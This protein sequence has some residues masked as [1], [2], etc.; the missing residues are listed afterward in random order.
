MNAKSSES[1]FASGASG[2]EVRTLIK[3][4]AI[5]HWSLST[6]DVK[7]AFLNAPAAQDRGVVIVQP[8]RI[9]QEAGVLQD[10]KE[11]W[12]VKKALYGL[13]TSPR[14]WCDHRDGKIKNFQWLR[15]GR[16][17]RVQATPQTDIWLVQEQ[18]EQNVWMTKGALATYVDD[19]LMVGETEII[20]G[21]IDQVKMHWKIGEPE[22]VMEGREPVRLLGMEI[23]KR[24]TSYVVHQQAYITNLLKE[25]DEKDRCA[26]S[27]VRT[28]E[29]EEQPT[30]DQVLQAQKETG[31]L[32]WVAG[33]TR[34][35]LSLGV[36]V[37]SQWASKRPLQVINIGKQLRAH[38]RETIDEVMAMT[39]DGGEVEEKTIGDEK[40]T[41]QA[42]DVYT[43]ASYGSSELKSISGVVVFV[44]GTPV[45]WQTT[46]QPFI[47]LS[48]A[49]AELMALLEGLVAGRST[50]ALVEAMT[51]EKARVALHSDS[52]AAIAIATGTTS[53]WRT[54]HLRIR[55]AGLT[56]AIKEKEITLDHVSGK[57]LVADGFTKQLVGPALGRFKRALALRG[58]EKEE[59]A[60]K[61]IDITKKVD[62]GFTRGI[63]LLVAAASLL[64][65]VEAA[66][67][68][69][70][71]STSEWWIIVLITAAIAVLVDIAFRV[72]TSGIQR[73]FRPK[74]EIKVKLLSP[75]ARLPTRG[76][77]QAAGLDLYSNIETL[78]P[79][80]ESVLIKTGLAIELP[81]GTYGR[82]APRSS[83]AIRGIETGAGVVDRDFRGEV[84]VLL[85]NWSDDDLRVY[86]GDRVAQLVVERILEVGVNHVEDLSETQRGNRGFGYSAHEEA[87]PW[88]EH[89]DPLYQRQ[90][91]G[92]SHPVDRISM[93]TMRVRSSPETAPMAS[94]GQTS[95][96][97]REGPRPDRP[98]PAGHLEGTDPG[99]CH[100][101]VQIGEV[102][103]EVPAAVGQEGHEDLRVHDPGLRHRG[104][105]DAGA[106][107][108][109]R[110]ELGMTMSAWDRYMIRRGPR[111]DYGGTWV[112]LDSDGVHFIARDPGDGRG[113]NPRAE[114]AAPGSREQ[115]QDGDG[116]EQPEEHRR[117]G[118]P[119]VEPLRLV[120]TVEPGIVL[121]KWCHEEEMAD[122]LRT[123]GFQR[124]LI[125]EA[126]RRVLSVPPRRTSAK[127]SW[128]YLID[129][130]GEKKVGIR[131]HYQDR[132]KLYDFEGNTLLE[133]T[134]GRWRMTVAWHATSRR[135]TILVDER[136]G[137]R[138]CLL[139]LWW[140]YTVF[141]TA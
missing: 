25:Y 97:D 54:G 114:S 69:K 83:L 10:S 115:P 49:E 7:T 123:P 85:R 110:A 121:G 126:V 103:S 104:A 59:I 138:G 36:G 20:Q 21:F 117:P 60:V 140:G 26:L 35:D 68:E 29:E 130:E 132:K 50:A 137:K 64:G 99:L 141:K 129:F 58:G 106:E 88:A 102:R 62:P 57:V 112:M 79:P 87:Y 105:Y 41:I 43:D 89:D 61:K 33:R 34:P 51:G 81:A 65:R 111:R 66:E 1:T 31:E 47:T 73:W 4:A 46:R 40:N 70:A 27:R 98:E 125:N 22:W 113:R 12:L 17:V 100:R 23:E 139:D 76:S 108:R 6:L 119:R 84:K 86:K 11:L 91:L 9:F 120:T 52:T 19:V 45:G 56:E 74:E 37:M 82:I 72:G 136:N 77:D 94:A 122:Y 107:E 24:G 80:G 135:K 71:E 15:G 131:V 42:V 134:W 48:T 96:V 133:E 95:A 44:G 67:V 128:D 78:V 5:N 63:G 109:R 39:A 16:P 30:A 55:A 124:G 8:P 14:D 32:L 28:P 92:T 93:R 116:G 90:E 75:E 38:L 3:M 127:D 53:S 13:V 18:D 101:S 2:I 118:P